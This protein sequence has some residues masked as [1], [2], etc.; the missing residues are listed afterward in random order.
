MLTSLQN[1]D[2]TGDVLTSEISAIEAKLERC[3]LESRE[4]D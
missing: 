3:I 2:E 1:F 4:K